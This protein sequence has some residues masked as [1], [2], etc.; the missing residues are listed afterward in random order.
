METIYACRPKVETQVLAEFTDLSLELE[1]IIKKQSKLDAD[2][3]DLFRLANSDFS[4]YKK[5]S[6][7]WQTSNLA[8]HRYIEAQKLLSR[9][10]C[11]LITSRILHLTKD[12]KESKANQQ[13]EID[14]IETFLKQAQNREKNNYLDWLEANHDSPLN[15]LKE[16]QEIREL[17][18]KA[19][20]LFL[21][22]AQENTKNQKPN[23]L[24]FKL[25]IE[26]LFQIQSNKVGSNRLLELTDKEGFFGNLEAI[27]NV[28]FENLLEL[29]I[30]VNQLPK[31]LI[32]LG[33]IVLD[34]QI[35]EKVFDK[36]SFN[37]PKFQDE[38]NC[39]NYA[40]FEGFAQ[41]D[42]VVPKYPN[43]SKESQVANTLSV[44]KFMYAVFG[45]TRIS[46]LIS[47]LANIANFLNTDMYQVAKV[48]LDNIIYQ[49][50]GDVFK[51]LI[52]N[53][54]IADLSTFKRFIA[55]SDDR[56]Y[57]KWKELSQIM[58]TL[59]LLEHL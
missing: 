58:E 7:Y 13:I 29:G 18:D 44:L 56:N 35:R 42:F 36:L 27:R 19:A 43:Y 21:E 46:F 54:D 51:A 12:L 47:E 49:N 23:S 15:Q 41:E 25:G 5:T 52:E 16:Q 24:F 37:Y 11:P 32:F 45:I 8:I 34:D 38:I 20:Q 28:A 39:Q 17:I 50:Q 4:N 53:T 22:I 3:Y 55:S 33:K 6:V 10:N 30:G 40:D 31:L 2:T 26:E 1:R 57:Q 48:G 59:K 14:K 9:A